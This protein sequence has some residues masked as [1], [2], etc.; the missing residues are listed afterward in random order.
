M[1]KTLI[2]ARLQA[3]FYR[4]PRAGKKPRNMWGA[5]IFIALY[6]IV[7]FGSIFM[8]NY[9]VLGSAFI[10]NG[11]LENLYFAIAAFTSMMLGFVGSV[12]MTQNQLYQ[13]KDNE[14]LLSMPIKPSVILASR[15][16]VLYIWAFLFSAINFI[17]AMLVYIQYGVKAAAV[18]MMFVELLTIP[19]F[20][21]T[22][23]FL[24]AWLLQ[25]ITS[26]LK[27]KTLFNII[28]VLLFSG[29]Y[30]VFCTRIYSVTLMMVESS[31][32]VLKA[33]KARLY[34]FFMCGAAIATGDLL[35]VF[36]E[37]V[38][39]LVPFAIAVWIL[40]KTFIKIATT[41]AKVAKIA[42]K[43][44]KLKASSLRKAVTMK[45]LRRFASSSTYVVN[46]IMGL[47]MMVAA[48]VYIAIKS[49]YLF[50]TIGQIF[51]SGLS[52]KYI[53][54]GVIVAVAS[55]STIT[56]ITVCS[57]SLEGKNLWII[58][59]APIPTR[60]ILMGKLYAHLYIA[61]PFSVISGIA[62]NF[63]GHMDLFARIMAILMPVIVQVFTA[64]F[65]LYI[66]LLLPKLDWTNEAQAIKQSGA[67]FIVAFGGMGLVALVIILFAALY[68]YVSANLM[69]LLITVFFVINSFLIYLWLTKKGEKRFEA[70]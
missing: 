35:S 5:F 44:E 46:G 54:A 69:L 58:K 39:T 43:R 8:Q 24:I 19:F 29:V 61:L 13:A 41:K 14:L 68:K 48:S 33:F 51:G 52:D 34:P 62:L 18:L 32:A 40:S 9:Q 67:A 36:M 26:R 55:L 20:S 60:D 6:L 25:M 16:V 1:L 22:A 49:E 2:M 15:I 3:S 57:I 38:L 42:Y 56:E 27:N 23:A 47:L 7:V 65:G 64:L 66:N 30:M 17:P 70:L 50:A 37:L 12:M 59:T 31:E 63:C 21:L 45:E 53:M 10:G 4:K 11:E 28:G